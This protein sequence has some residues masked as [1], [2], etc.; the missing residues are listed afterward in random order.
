M[1][2]G[3]RLLYQC[4]H[5]QK[6]FMCFQRFN[7]QSILMSDRL[8]GCITALSLTRYR[9]VTGC[10]LFHCQSIQQYSIFNF[11]VY[12]ISRR[13]IFS[14]FCTTVMMIRPMWSERNSQL[15]SSI[16]LFATFRTFNVVRN[17]ADAQKELHNFY[18]TSTILMP[19][20]NI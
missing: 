2:S 9:L 6:P 15:V 16:V 1:N 10:H 7:S 14:L 17:S 12:S 8:S 19:T 5:H 18:P 13:T 3:L 20:C 11:T 4:N